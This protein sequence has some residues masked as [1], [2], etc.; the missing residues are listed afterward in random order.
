MS[1]EEFLAQV[2][3]ILEYKRGQAVKLDPEMYPG[4]LTADVLS[5]SVSF[6]SK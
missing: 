5:V 6:V 2:K 1:S 3:D 4:K